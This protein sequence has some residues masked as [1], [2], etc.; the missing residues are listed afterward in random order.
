M[1]GNDL[2]TLAADVRGKLGDRPGVVVL[3]GVDGEKVSF[4]VATTKAAGRTGSPPGS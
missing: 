2:R 4:V 1:T 3:F